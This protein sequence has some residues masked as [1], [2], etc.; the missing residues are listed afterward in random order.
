MDLLFADLIKEKK[1][2][3]KGMTSKSQTKESIAVKAS[4]IKVTTKSEL[5]EEEAPSQYPKEERW[6][7]TLKELDAKVYPFPN[8][9]VPM[10]LDKFLAKKVTDLPAS[11][12]P[13]EINKVGDPRYCKFHRVP[14]HP[15]SKCC[16]L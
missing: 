3:R 16:I 6:R 9:D 4:S 2:F 11:K 13:E 12:R 7:P 15:T 14:G 1:D 10:I 5:K 8:L